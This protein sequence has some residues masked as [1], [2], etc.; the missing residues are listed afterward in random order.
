MI[1]KG[2]IQV[3]TGNG[4]GKTTAAIGQV[5]RI[6]A[7]GGRVCIIQFFKPKQIGE[8]KLL[9]RTFPRQIKIYSI[10]TKH[11]FFLSKKNKQV[12][13]RIKTE[14]IKEW[15]KIKNGIFKNKYDLIVFDEINIALRDKFIPLKDFIE[16]LKRKPVSGEWILTGRGIPSQIIKEADLVTEMKEV[17]HYLKS[18]LKARK[19][20]EY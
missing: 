18:G 4:K 13:P 9:K 5:I 1:K 7:Y 8:I 20:I 12:P 2:Q 11:P 6:L 19:G 14:C 10:C 16:F 17:K 15:Q 3:C